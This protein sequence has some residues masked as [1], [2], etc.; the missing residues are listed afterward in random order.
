MRVTI[1]AHNRELEGVVIEE[2]AVLAV[3]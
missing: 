1:I 3:G 2:D